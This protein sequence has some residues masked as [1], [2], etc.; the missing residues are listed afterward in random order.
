MST[1]AISLHFSEVQVA[2]CTMDFAL[3][4]L[5]LYSLFL[6]W[7][8]SSH[9]HIHENTHD[10]KQLPVFHLECEHSFWY[11]LA[12]V[13]DIILQDS[14]DQNDL[15]SAWVLSSLLTSEC[16]VLML[17]WQFLFTPN[18]ILFS[19]IIEMF[20]TIHKEHSAVPLYCKE[21]RY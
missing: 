3:W 9:K 5:V 18:L 10:L 8:N 7:L 16:S 13:S 15:A 14:H 17:L 6:P 12:S 1:F 21:K 11:V 4:L 2:H 19:V 20:W